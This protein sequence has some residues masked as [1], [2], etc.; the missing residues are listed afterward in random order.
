MLSTLDQKVDPRHSALILVDVQND[1]CAEGGA[2]HR[3]GRDLTLVKR[4]IPRL[5]QLLEAVIDA[6]RARLRLAKLEGDAAFFYVS[7]PAGT[8]P[9]LAFAA[10][11]IP[12]PIIIFPRSGWS[13][14]GAAAMAPMSRIRFARPVNGTETSFK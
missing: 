1:F 2:M 14:P 3:D 10:S 5:A 8:E 7:F 12:V 4:M 13:R 6:T 9:S 11:I